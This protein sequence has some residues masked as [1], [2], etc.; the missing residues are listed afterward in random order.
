MGLEELECR[1]W[2]LDLVVRHVLQEVERASLTPHFVQAP[3]QV[4]VCM[5]GVCVAKISCPL[6]FG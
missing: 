1:G 3:V 6:N 5:S 2:V 4:G